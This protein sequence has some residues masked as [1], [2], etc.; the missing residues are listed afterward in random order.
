[1]SKEKKYYTSY[2]AMPP[3][4]RFWVHSELCY[5]EAELNFRA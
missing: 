5:T 2:Q 1:M 4:S 3:N